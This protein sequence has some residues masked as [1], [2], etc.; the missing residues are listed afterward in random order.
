MNDLA[1]TPPH[2]FSLLAPEDTIPE[3]GEI[4]FY[5]APQNRWG[6]PRNHDV[7]IPYGHPA[8]R[9]L[10]HLAA[11]EQPQVI[12]DTSE[13]VTWPK[14]KPEMTPEDMLSVH[15]SQAKR[16]TIKGEDSK[17]VKDKRRWDIVPL[18]LF[19]PVIDVFWNA[20]KKYKRCSW[21][22]CKPEE[23]VPKYYAAMV[24]HIEAYASG[25]WSDPESGLPHLAHAVA[26]ALIVLYHGAT[27]ECVRRFL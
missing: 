18:S 4:A 1:L 8:S 23:V 22:H 7:T 20:N 3:H 13:C 2:G 10:Y 16:E 14:G 21:V 17:P 19:A 25:E 9:C 27:H 15:N 5:I 12:G 11:R 6:N 26:S 24:R